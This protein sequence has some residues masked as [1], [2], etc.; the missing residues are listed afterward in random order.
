MY[1]NQYR[2]MQDA[3][4]AGTV[5]IGNMGIEAPKLGELAEI[6]QAFDSELNNLHKAIARTRNLVSGPEAAL[7]SCAEL[8]ATAG[9]SGTS[10]RP[11]HGTANSPTAAR[12]AP[13]FGDA[14]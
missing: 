13:T 10:R 2:G 1:E 5:P 14:A 9:G 6:R 12:P 7:H 8:T 11:R 3:R 4:A